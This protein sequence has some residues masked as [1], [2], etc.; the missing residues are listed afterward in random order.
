M[1]RVGEG[2]GLRDRGENEAARRLFTELW[3]DIGGGD[4][5]AF[6]RCAIAHSMADACENA[7]DELCWDLR[8]LEAAEFL[9][10]AR[11]AEGGVDA[12]VTVLYP[13]LHLNLSE[14]YRKL[15]DVQRA[16][17]HLQRGQNSLGALPNDGYLA[18]IREGFDRL[19]HALA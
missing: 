10:D 11:V 15:G 5:D 18:M 19:A 2:I 1:L 12:P 4:G 16:R 9:T 17:D 3:R 7:E 6:H 14:C 8:A 13:S